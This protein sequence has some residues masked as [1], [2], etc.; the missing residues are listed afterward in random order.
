MLAIVDGVP[1]TLPLDGF[2]THWIDAPDR[3]DRP[4]HAR[5]GCARPRSACTSCARTSRRS[6]R[7]T[8]SSHSSAAPR[9]STRRATGLQVP[10]RRSTTSRP[11]RSCRCS[12]AA[13]PPS[14]VR[15][16]ST[17]PRSSR[18]RSRTSRTILADARAAAHDHPRRAHRDR[19]PLRRRPPHAD[20]A[21]FDGDMSM[22]DLIPEEEM[23]VTVTRDGYIKRTR[24]DNYR[25]QHRGGKG[26]RVRSCAPMTSS[27]TSSSRRRTTGCS[28]SRTRAA[29]TA[30]R[31]TRCPRPGVTPRVSTSRTCSRCSRVRRSRRSST[32]AITA[33][34]TYLVLATRGGLVKKTRLTEYD[35][36]RQGGVIA[37]KLRGRGGR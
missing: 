28:S 14:S 13:S 33:S 24:S 22:E 29:S 11:T 31:P 8:R 6:T 19:R 1:R 2:I 35:T 3:G 36:N 4:A 27:S 16:S 25:S 34:P 10:A 5:T 15:R 12:C 32:S 20:P 18:R 37:I 17:R 23:V 7:S 9:R 30:P 26:S 21:G